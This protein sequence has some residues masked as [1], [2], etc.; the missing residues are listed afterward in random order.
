[1][2]Y[3]RD[4]ALALCKTNIH[5]NAILAEIN[6]PGEYNAII[7]NYLLTPPIH[8]MYGPP[9]PPAS[10]LLLLLLLMYTWYMFEN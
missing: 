7:T 5:P 3:N 1:M 8:G 4:E 6:M 2:N 9:P 10:P